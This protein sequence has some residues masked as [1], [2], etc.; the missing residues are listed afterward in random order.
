GLGGAQGFA[1]TAAGVAALNSAGHYLQPPPEPRPEATREEVDRYRFAKT[2][3]DAVQMGLRFLM[4]NKPGGGGGKPEF[5]IRPDIH[6]FYGH[7]YAVQ[8][9]WTAGGK[10]FEEWFPAI[11]EELLGT[12]R[13]DGCWQDAIC[14]HYGTAMACI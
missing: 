1:R 5:F 2:A 6:Y 4:Q 13:Q 12:Q 9:M 3:T 11:R 8:V 14:S 10:Y 7:Y